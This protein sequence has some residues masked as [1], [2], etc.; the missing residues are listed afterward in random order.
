[1][2]WPELPECGGHFG[3]SLQGGRHAEH[4][5]W[6]AALFEFAQQAPHARPRAVFVN[7]FHADVAR[8]KG[9]GVE[10]FREKLLRTCIAM[11]HAVLATLLIVQN[12]LHR[13]ARATG[14]TRMRHIAAIASEITGIRGGG[15]VEGHMSRK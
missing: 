11:Q 8:G 7:A 5:Q 10:H 12:K 15:V 1:M 3:R 9:R 4:G 6:Q 14:P 13:D 2:S